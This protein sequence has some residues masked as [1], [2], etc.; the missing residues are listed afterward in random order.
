MAAESYQ[1]CVTVRIPEIYELKEA[2][3]DR[4]LGPDIDICGGDQTHVGGLALLFANRRHLDRSKTWR[5][6]GH[7]TKNAEGSIAMACPKWLRDSLQTLCRLLAF[8]NV[9]PACLVGHCVLLVSE[10]E[11][12]RRIHRH[13][14]LGG[15]KSH[16][17]WQS[18]R[19]IYHPVWSRSDWTL[20]HRASVL[21][22]VVSNRKLP[23]CDNSDRTQTSYSYSR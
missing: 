6:I 14:Q 19:R 21:S 8:N 11:S 23:T 17:I 15:S 3:I 10:S 18:D 9:V 4:F 13:H 1:F 20:V 22:A 7:Y 16:R 12:F 5:L 2:E